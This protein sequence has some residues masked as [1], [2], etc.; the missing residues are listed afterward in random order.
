MI[1]SLQKGH[2]LLQSNEAMISLLLSSRMTTETRIRSLEMLTKC[3]QGANSSHRD[4]SKCP[5]SR[6][7]N[8]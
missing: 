2:P 1:T 4:N 7:N 8:H 5:K 6:F 3:L